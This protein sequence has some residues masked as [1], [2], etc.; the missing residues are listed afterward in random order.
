MYA[1][2]VQLP[3]ARMSTK[4][5]RAQ[6]LRTGFVRLVSR[7]RLVSLLREPARRPPTA[8]AAHARNVPVVIT[9]PALAMTR[10]TAF[11]RFA[12]ILA[13]LGR[14]KPRHALAAPTVFVRLVP[15]ARQVCLRPSAAVF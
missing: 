15:I 14:M 12:E 3:A 6:L 7:A 10:Q 5:R 1:Q 8:N 11:V 2:R 13:R 9:R 4:A